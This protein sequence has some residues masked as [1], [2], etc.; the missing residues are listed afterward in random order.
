[1][2]KGGKEERKR[3]RQPLLCFLLLVLPFLCVSPPPFRWA[4][5]SRPTEQ[6]GP[7]RLLQVVFGLSVAALSGLQGRDPCGSMALGPVTL[8][9]VPLGCNFVLLTLL[10]PSCSVCFA[11]P[12]SQTHVSVFH[13]CTHGSERCFGFSAQGDGAPGDGAPGDGPRATAPR[14]TARRATAR[15]VTAL[16]RLPY[17]PQHYLR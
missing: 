10:G 6:E 7:W 8:L 1:M 9:C 2:K 3:G 12:L 17:G 16:S 5:V 14:V 13:T 4:P 15:R 11:L